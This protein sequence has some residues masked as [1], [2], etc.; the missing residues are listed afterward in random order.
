MHDQAEAC[1]R[2]ELTYSA[3]FQLNRGV[4]QGSVLSP[5]LFLLVI[6]SLLV[7]LESS[8]T[9]ASTNSIYLGP[10][11]HADNLRSITAN[12][13]LHEKQVS[14]VKRFTQDNGLQLNME[15]LEF[16]QHSSVIPRIESMDV[17]DTTI[18]SSSNRSCMV[19]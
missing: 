3:K 2:V 6:D 14:V 17:G 15:K 7:E 19:T 12:I 8:G 18:F 9:G 16:L 4:K 10:L 13:A 11:G 5:L 1:V